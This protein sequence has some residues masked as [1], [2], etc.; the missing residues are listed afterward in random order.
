VRKPRLH[1]GIDEAGIDLPVEL[2]NDVGGR[3][4]GGCDASYRTRLVARH[5]IADGREGRHQFRSRC[6]RHRKGPQP[7]VPD[8]LDRRRHV[9]EYRLHLATHHVRKR[10]AVPRY[11]TWTK[12][13]S[14]IILNSSPDIWFEVPIPGEAK[15]ILPGLALA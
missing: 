13:T 12:L 11:G 5:E 6:S 4:L 15:L 10:G 9:V 2:I 1:L 8:V 7:P 14:A 3:S